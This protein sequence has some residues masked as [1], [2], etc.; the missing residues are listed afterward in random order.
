MDENAYLDF[1]SNKSFIDPPTGIVGDLPDL[2]PKLKPFQADIVKWALRRGR[3]AIFAD[4]G[5]GKSF[6]QL[7]WADKVRNHTQGRVLVLAPLAVARQTENEAKKWGIDG[8]H[9]VK[10]N[11]DRGN[12]VYVTNYD[13][14]HK[15]NPDDFSGIVLDESSII[16]N[17]DGKTRTTIIDQFKNTPWKLAATATPSPNDFME[18]GNHSEFLNAM[19]QHE[20]L[21]TFFLHDGGS[22]QNWRLKGHAEDEFWRWVA[23]W[24][25]LI[26]HPRDLGY[27]DDGYDLPPVNKHQI[28]V[29]TSHDPE[30][31]GMLFHVEASSL[32][33]RIRARKDTISDRVNAAIDVVK[34]NPNEPW[35]IWCGLNDEA[36][37]MQS[38]IQDAIQVSGSNKE[39]EKEDRLLGFSS[40]KYRILVT[41]PKIAGMGMNWQH[42]SNMVFVGLNDS[43]EQMYQAI[44]RCWRFGQE[45]EV[46]VYIVASDREGAVV[47]NVARK[48]GEALRMADNMLKHMIDIQRENISAASRNVDKYRGIE[49]MKLP[50]WV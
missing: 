50:E 45:K 5:L 19:T 46:N 31:T 16:K 43:F 30:D 47:K 7:E 37:M 10:D 39:D 33:D 27:N 1:L 26:K 25:V 28:T 40:G 11:E 41:K 12:I 6:M 17:V 44:R 15:F 14:L 8:V 42:C 18:L 29:K 32:Q 35:L 3:A 4:T 48:E 38:G 23:S 22:T 49:K 9:A 21:A 36:D 2:N 13:K 34:S 20:M 24:A